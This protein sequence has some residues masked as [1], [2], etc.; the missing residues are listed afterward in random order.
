MS[1]GPLPAAAVILGYGLPLPESRLLHKNKNNEINT[2]S[3]FVNYIVFFRQ[4]VLTVELCILFFFF[5]PKII[6]CYHSV[7]F[8]DQM[9]TRLTCVVFSLPVSTWRCFTQEAPEYREAAQ[10]C[11]EI[12]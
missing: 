4:M 6:H 7:A 10:R 3:I 5:P 2:D 12:K 11:G 1:T 8:W 9:E